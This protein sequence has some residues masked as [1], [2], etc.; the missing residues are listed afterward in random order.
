MN[1]VAVILT[2][3]SRRIL[4]VNRDFEA[5]TG[6]EI[7][8][9]IGMN[10]GQ[11]LQGPKTEP[12]AIERIR[13]GLAREEPFKE[14]ITNYRKNGE[15]YNCKLVIHPIHNKNEELVNF[16]AFEVDGDTVVNENRISLLNIKDRYRTSSLRGMDELQLFE[17]I[18]EVMLTEKLYLDADLTL[19]KLSAH[20][21]TNTKYLSQ[22]INHHGSANFL[23]F[24]NA[25]RIDAFIERI[26]AEDFRRQTFYGIAQR[27]GFKNK[28]TFYKVFRDV[29]GKTPKA[30]TDAL[31]RLENNKN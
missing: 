26:K 28:S 14:T 31:M 16:L 18:K 23:T 13:Q 9:V 3:A 24:I 10:P 25:Y 29:T 19:R 27:C 22:V 30:F 4:W 5:M 17:R 1:Q 2:D 21:D 8:E 7:G 6:Y 15:A 12:D 20:L 11:I